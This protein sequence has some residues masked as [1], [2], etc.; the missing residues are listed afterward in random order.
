MCFSP[1]DFTLYPDA[2]NQ[3]HQKGRALRLLSLTLKSHQ[4]PARLMAS[5]KNV[6]RKSKVFDPVPFS[7]LQLRFF[8][9]VRAIISY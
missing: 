3:P 5:N 4:A 2:E 1:A 8:G 6:C 7:I 9:G